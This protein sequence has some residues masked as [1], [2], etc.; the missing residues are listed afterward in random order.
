MLEDSNSMRGSWRL[1]EVEEAAP[2][3]D[4]K[5][6]DVTIKYKNLND[7]KFYTGGKDVILKRSV[8]K[9]VLVL[10]IEERN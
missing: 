8:H 10:P 3:R 4:G 9:L 7:D 5:V 6:R 2:G 1:A